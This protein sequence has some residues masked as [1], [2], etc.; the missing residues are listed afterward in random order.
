M[1]MNVEVHLLFGIILIT[2]ILF[3]SG[4]VETRVDFIKK[5]G[6]VLCVLPPNGIW[7][8]GSF[9]GTNTVEACLYVGGIPR[10]TK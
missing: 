8:Q 6:E 1:N 5:N 9:V 2:A 3:L 7:K 4:C 10:N